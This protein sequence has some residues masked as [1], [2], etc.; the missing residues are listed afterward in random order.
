MLLGFA[1]FV[2]RFVLAGVF[3]RAGAAKVRNLDDLELA[4][5]NY[6]L[7]PPGLVR[8]VARG[9]P[10]AEIG[11]G[12][13]LTVGLFSGVVSITL[14]ALLA[15]FAVAVAVNLLRGRSFDCGC[16]GAAPAR[17]S[18]WHV[19]YNFVMV[20]L[21]LS[22]AAWGSAAFSVRAGWRLAPVSGMASNAIV[23]MLAVVVLVFVTAAVAKR[24][25]AA[26]DIMQAVTRKPAMSVPVSFIR[27]E[28]S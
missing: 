12:L 28:S 17:I 21:A 1:V 11:G 22:V 20:L 5:R 10:F 6:R 13:L 3:V 2:A 23:P 16:A 19:L 18:W 14:A 27:K 7:M 8:P 4:T 25:L 26:W 15:V 24:A 9:L